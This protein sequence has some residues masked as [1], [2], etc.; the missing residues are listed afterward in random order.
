MIGLDDSITLS[1]WMSTNATDTLPS[2]H[3]Q[4]YGMEVLEEDIGKDF[5]ATS[6]SRTHG[7][8]LSSIPPD[9]VGA[10]GNKNSEDAIVTSPDGFE[11]MT[12]TDTYNGQVKRKVTEIE[13][14]KEVPF[15]NPS[16]K[17]RKTAMDPDKEPRLLSMEVEIQAAVVPMSTGEEIPPGFED[18]D[19]DILAM[20]RDIVDFV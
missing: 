12:L 5:L 11:K 1:E 2:N 16:A 10:F 13:L 15:C 18:V 8:R 6:M 14:E 19:P 3:G 9:I 17:K 7:G 20:F 4:A